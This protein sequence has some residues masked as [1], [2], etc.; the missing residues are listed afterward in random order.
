MSD[1]ILSGKNVGRGFEQKHVREA[2]ETAIDRHQ[3][4]NKIAYYQSPVN[5]VVTLAHGPANKVG[6][7]QYTLPSV[8]S[9]TTQVQ[10]AGFKQVNTRG[11]REVAVTTYTMKGMQQLHYDVPNNK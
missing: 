11:Q 4:R 2:G 10:G 8:N 9:T 6:P 3:A 1:R 7:N 5:T